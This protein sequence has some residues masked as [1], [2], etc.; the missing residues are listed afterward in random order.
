[1]ETSA[2]SAADSNCLELKMAAA[3]Q[4]GYANELARRQVLG[5][6]VSAID[7]VEF[8]EQRKVCARDLHINEVIHGQSRLFQDG[9]DLVEQDLD[10]VCDFG[11]RFAGFIQTDAPREVE[12]VSGENAVTERKLRIG[13]GKV[14]GAARR[15]RGRLGECA[16]DRKRSRSGKHQECKTCPS[17]QRGLAIALHHVLLMLWRSYVAMTA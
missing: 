4:R 13:I 6:E 9:L 10:F 3:Q 14:D 16:A 12:R 7:T 15:L 11:R 2:R 8:I 5:S 17:I 1:M